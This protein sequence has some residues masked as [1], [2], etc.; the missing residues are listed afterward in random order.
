MKSTDNNLLNEI[1]DEIKIIDEDT[2]Q[3]KFDN[4]IFKLVQDY[5]S[6]REDLN[7]P[8]I[9]LE[10]SEKIKA[11]KVGALLDFCIWSTEDNGAKQA[12]E[13]EKWMHSNN[14]RKIEVALSITNAFPLDDFK[15]LKSKLE[16]FKKTFPR[17]EKLCDLRMAGV[18]KMIQKHEKKAVDNSFKAKVLR[19]LNLTKT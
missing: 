5:L 9:I 11:I 17:L 7:Y 6:T 18:E 19:Y 13:I 10:A 14:E 2:L 12:K 8:L 16:E 15:L 3:I 4:K 1:Y